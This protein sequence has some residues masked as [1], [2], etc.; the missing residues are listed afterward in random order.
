MYRM[1]VC[2]LLFPGFHAIVSAQ[3]NAGA[4]RHPAIPP[5]EKNFYIG[6]PAEWVQPKTPWGDPDLQGIYP[7]SFVGSVPMQRC[8]GRQRPGGP[9]CDPDKAFLTEAEFKAAQDRYAK[10][11]NQF[12][13]AKEQG[14]VPANF[15][16]ESAPPSA[17]P[18]SSSIRPT[19]SFPP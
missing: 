2:G 9:P 6:T 13:Q 11:P 4:Q 14:Q 16:E 12:D 15:S 10:A 19:A 8:A 1:A 18:P 3:S 7:E 5:S 17:R